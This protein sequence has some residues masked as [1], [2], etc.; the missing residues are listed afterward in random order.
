MT[1][2]FIDLPYFGLYD[3]GLFLIIMGL[4]VPPNLFSSYLV[5]SLG[6]SV[7]FFTMYNRPSAFT[8]IGYPRT[9]TS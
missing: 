6:S 2:I 8:N 3:F 4:T 5:N 7:P 9:D 1:L